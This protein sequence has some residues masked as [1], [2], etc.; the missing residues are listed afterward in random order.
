VRRSLG[1]M[2]SGSADERQALLGCPAITRRWRERLLRP[3]SE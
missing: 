1:V 2:V 3:A